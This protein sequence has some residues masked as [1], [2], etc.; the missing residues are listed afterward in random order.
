MAHADGLVL[1][2][3]S[4]ES[5]DVSEAR[6]SRASPPSC[7]SCP[8]LQQVACER[9]SGHCLRVPGSPAPRSD[10]AVCDRILAACRT[11]DAP[12]AAALPVVQLSRGSGSGG[13]WRSGGSGG[14]VEECAEALVLAPLQAA[15]A[16]AAAPRRSAG[17]VS[18]V[19]GS[20]RGSSSGWSLSDISARLR[21]RR[22]ARCVRRGCL[23]VRAPAYCVRRADACAASFSAQRDSTNEL[24]VDMRSLFAAAAAEGGAAA[25]WAAS[26]SLDFEALWCARAA[27][28]SRHARFC[29]ETL[30]HARAPE[31]VCVLPPLP[32]R[33]AAATFG[34][35]GDAWQDMED[36]LAPSSATPGGRSR[37]I[38]SWS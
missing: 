35:S 4:P 2:R 19:G 16:A 20:P 31:T 6:S 10:W 24:A 25:A 12:G 15:A 37:M 1:R 29:G 3:S 9:G 36:A 11:H 21:A 32:T 34:G 13:L 38:R 28:R 33:R 30:P 26:V 14:S 5:P 27:R 18:G 22:Y 8:I 17:G 7:A 23:R